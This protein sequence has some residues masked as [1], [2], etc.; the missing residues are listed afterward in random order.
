LSLWAR[1]VALLAP[2]KPAKPA[3]E[4][5][6]SEVAATKSSEAERWTTASSGVRTTAQWLATALGA[7]AGVIFGAGPLINNDTDVSAW[8]AR[9][10]ALVLV[11]AAAGV[12]GVVAIVS[13]LV[14]A[15]MPSEVTL[16]G[17]PKALL[18][19]IEASP[20]DYLPVG[21]TTVTDF[22]DRL[23]SFTRAAAQ[24]EIAARRETDA[25]KKS[26]LVDR[27]KIQ[28]ANR[29]YFREKRSELYAQ[30]KYYVES[31]RLG[32]ARN[33]AWFA[34]AAIAAVL[35][36]S[37]FT[38]VTHAPAEDQADDAPAPQGAL[39][40]P[41]TGAEALWAALELDKC[42]VGGVDDGVPV[43]LLGTTGENDD[44]YRV[45][46]LGQPTGCSRY[47]FTVSDELV[48][49]VVPEPVEVELTEPTPSSGR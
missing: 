21:I 5:A 1:V 16:D 24:L 3:V 49:V 38:F 47:S 19:R 35:G 46:T 23:S 40:I 13:R 9:R 42:A 14:L 31:G 15:M 26:L 39:L 44:H 34:T 22:R 30:A 36:I 32:G 17:L 7:I 29:D 33:A 12:L 27:A 48:D 18:G 2:A 37:C 10:W 8:D 6:V 25:A 28:A 41:K 43:L 4:P 20:A 45:Q 11:A